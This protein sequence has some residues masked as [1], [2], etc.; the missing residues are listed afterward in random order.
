LTKPGTLPRKEREKRRHIQEILKAAQVVFARQGYN[1]AK[2][3]DIAREAEFSVGYLYQIWEGK[4]DLYISILK[5]KSREFKKYLSRKIEESDDPFEKINILID[6]HFDF[7]EENK[8]FFRIY[9][10]ETSRAEVHL[11]SETGKELVRSYNRY[12]AFVEKIF[13]DGVEKGVFVS[14]PPEDLA[15]SLKGLIFAFAKDCLRRK[16]GVDF[17]A[18]ARTMK[19]VFFG[20]TL[21]EACSSELGYSGEWGSRK[22]KPVPKGRR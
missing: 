2:M 5:E 16:G 3:S 9:I 12:L 8:D 13:A 19:R 22:G 7:I 1:K 17:E 14:L 18:R 6:A 15:L 10:S 4:K 11:Y 20:A 21:T